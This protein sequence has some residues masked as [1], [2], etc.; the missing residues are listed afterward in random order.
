MRRILVLLALAG[1]VAAMTVTPEVAAAQPDGEE[2][3]INVQSQGEIRI[4]V[5][6]KR[7]AELLP[8]TKIRDGDVLELE[9]EATLSLVFYGSGRIERWTGPGTV[10][11]SASQ[12]ASDDATVEVM[13]ADES[14]GAAVSHIPVIIRRAELGRGGQAMFRGPQAEQAKLD[15]HERQQVEEARVQY[16]RIRGLTP[17]GDIV[18]E[19]YLASV[20][21]GVS[22]YEESIGVLNEARSRCPDCE[23][24]TLLLEWLQNSEVSEDGHPDEFQVPK[25]KDKGKKRR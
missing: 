9:A 12:G 3:A 25:G 16:S 6:G 19:L 8:F 5:G 2:S 10:R 20:L 22:L 4:R 18:P 7:Y 13:E 15:E 1:S 21:L 24:P 14:L 11:V 17:D 23:A